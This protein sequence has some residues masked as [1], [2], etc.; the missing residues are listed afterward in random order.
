M[1]ASMR[2]LLCVLVIASAAVL[3]CT[4][5]CVEA[6]AQSVNLGQ[7]Q[8]PRTDKDLDANKAYLMGA[9]DAVIVINQSL[10]EK[11]FCLPTAPPG[12]SFE[13]AN[14]LI[15]HWASTTSGSSDLSLGRILIY[16]LKQAYP[17]RR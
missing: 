4:A 9:V 14:K 15:M 13:Q 5:L 17:C 8:H 11:Q 2:A 1:K 16:A 10:D 3:L 7:Y 12:L 6:T